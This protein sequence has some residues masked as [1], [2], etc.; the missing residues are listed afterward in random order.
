MFHLTGQ[1]RRYFVIVVVV[2]VVVVEG[3]MESLK[4]LYFIDKQIYKQIGLL[5]FIS[6][7]S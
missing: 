1:A 2:V 3:N 5:R 4:T 6:K 7:F